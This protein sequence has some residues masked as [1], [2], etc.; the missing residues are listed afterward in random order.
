MFQP[1][2]TID[3]SCFNILH[4]YWVIQIQALIKTYTNFVTIF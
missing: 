2:S 3:L 4:V 1:F